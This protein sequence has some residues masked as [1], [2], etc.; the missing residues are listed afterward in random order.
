[1][2]GRMLFATTLI[3]G[4]CAGPAIASDFQ[5]MTLANELG[6]VLASEEMCALSFDQ[7]AIERWIEARVDADDMSFATNLNMMIQGTRYQFSGMSQSAKTAHCSQVRRVARANG[8]IG[9]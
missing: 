2:A 6:T 8:F 5:S 1:M 4:V 9:D 7:A 3:A